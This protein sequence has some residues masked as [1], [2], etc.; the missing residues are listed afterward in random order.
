M[1]AIM[2]YQEEYFIDGDET[3]AKPMILKDIVD[4]VGLIFP[5]SPA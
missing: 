3:E 5:Q 4:L 1:N 2:H